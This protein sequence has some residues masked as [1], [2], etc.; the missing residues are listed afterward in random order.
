MLNFPIFS[1]CTIF[2][3]TNNVFKFQFFYN[4]VNRR[5]CRNLHFCQ[6]VGRE[7]ISH[8]IL[9]FLSMNDVKIFFLCLKGIC[10]YFSGD[11]L[12]M[13]LPSFLSGYF[14]FPPV[15][16]RWIVQLASLV[17]LKLTL[18]K[19]NK[20]TGD[21]LTHTLHTYGT[22]TIVIRLVNTSVTSHNYHA[23]VVRIVK[24]YFLSNFQEVYILLT[25]VIMLNIEP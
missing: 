20:C 6:S 5:N 16:L 2:I 1:G 9:I 14:I 18:C 23:V 12:F 10:F 25:I 24:I 21:H 7:I 19:F 15:L 3:F 22:M 11:Y 17:H 8:C 13:S 4:L